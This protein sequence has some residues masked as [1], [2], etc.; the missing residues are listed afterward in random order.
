MSQGE[1]KCI[2][3]PCVQSEQCCPSS[4]CVDL[5]SAGRRQGKILKLFRDVDVD[6]DDGEEEEDACSKNMD[7]LQRNLT[8]TLRSSRQSIHQSNTINTTVCGV[9]VLYH[10]RFH[11]IPAPSP[12][13]HHQ[14]NPI[15]LIAMFAMSDK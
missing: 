3:K 8:V 9:C 7:F 15:T 5:H 4:V 1:E 10:L 11:S 2:N 6:V 12:K 14:T 13:E